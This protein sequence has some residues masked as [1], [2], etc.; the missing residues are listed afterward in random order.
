MLKRRRSQLLVSCSWCRTVT[1]SVETSTYATLAIA[2]PSILAEGAMSGIHYWLCTIR[3]TASLLTFTTYL[4]RQH[5]EVLHRL[6]QEILAHVGL[7]ATPTYDQVKR[8][9]YF[10]AILNETL[11]LFPPVPLNERTAL[12][13]CAIPTGSGRL[14]IP[15]GTQVVYLP[16][17]MQRRRDLWGPDAWDFD[18]GR[19]L[20]GRNEASV[21][22]PMWFVLFNA[23]PRMTHGF[24]FLTRE[25]GG[26]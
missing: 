4:L 6:R 1:C 5:P 15:A 9:K 13:A 25:A 26:N 24:D 14:Y 20:D 21:K 3:Q 8:M 22:D 18:P 19:W 10:Q 17:L 23:G 12:A 11:W 16:L 7:D 2:S